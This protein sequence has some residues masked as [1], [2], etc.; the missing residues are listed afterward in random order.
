MYYLGLEARQRENIY[1]DFAEALDDAAYV[2]ERLL[3]PI[4]IF[5]L[6]PNKKSILVK[7]V[8][9]NSGRRPLGKKTFLEK[10]TK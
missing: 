10:T 5:T 6:L 3:I 4:R 9:P 2:A 1:N 7:V 8:Q